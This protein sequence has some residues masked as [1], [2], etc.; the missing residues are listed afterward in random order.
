MCE[1]VSSSA[2]TKTASQLPAI[3]KPP[4]PPTI[5]GFHAVL[6]S[7]VTTRH[8]AHHSHVGSVSLR[9]GDA[10]VFHDPL[11]RSPLLPSITAVIAETPGTV[12][13]H[14]L[15][16][17]LQG[18]RLKCKSETWS[19]ATQRSATYP[20]LHQ[21]HSEIQHRF[22]QLWYLMANSFIKHLMGG[23]KW[24]RRSCRKWHEYSR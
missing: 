9:C 14:L 16:Q 7:A 12:H 1:G 23:V 6:F 15:R 21:S 19:D 18:A 10:S 20:V 13:Q 3:L 24:D 8:F 4:P 11:I 22:H 17:N 5:K 2:Q